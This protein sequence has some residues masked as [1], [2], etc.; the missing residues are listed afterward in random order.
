MSM[1]LGTSRTFSSFENVLRLRGASVSGKASPPAG[2]SRGKR[3]TIRTNGATTNP[4][5]DGRFLA[6]A[7][8]ANSAAFGGNFSSPAAACLRPTIPATWPRS[9]RDAPGDRDGSAVPAL[10]RKRR[11]G[12]ASRST[13]GGQEGRPRRVAVASSPP[14]AARRRRGHR[15]RT[16]EARS[17]RPVPPEAVSR[18]STERLWTSTIPLCDRRKTN[19][20]GDGHAEV[21]AQRRRRGSCRPRDRRGCSG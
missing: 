3:G 1:R 19:E 13:R 11:T 7:A 4:I 17:F 10:P 16:S 8:S 14:I 9:S 6:N 15:T 12:S 18:C 20:G 5:R 21:P 2:L